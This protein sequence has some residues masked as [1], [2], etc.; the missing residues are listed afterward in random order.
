MTIPLHLR[1]LLG[2]QDGDYVRLTVVE[3]VKRT[4]SESHSALEQ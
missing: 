4:K 1:E 3:V 2:I